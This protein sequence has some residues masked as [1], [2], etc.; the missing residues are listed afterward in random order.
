[1]EEFPLIQAAYIQETAATDGARVLTLNVR[2]SGEDITS[3]MNSHFYTVPVLLDAHYGTSLLYG[4][5]GIP[6]T[7]FI[8]R[9]GIIKYIKRGAF[10]SQS[11]I[12]YGLGKIS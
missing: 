8:D 12:Q 6:M 7:F 4:V 2:E 5:S 10:L 9:D 1:V 3:F 11:E